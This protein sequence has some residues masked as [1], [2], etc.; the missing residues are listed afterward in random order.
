MVM[1]MISFT[2]MM[3]RQHCVTNGMLVLPLLTLSFT[4]CVLAG[5]MTCFRRLDRIQ[6]A[7]FK[8][9]THG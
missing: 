5:V 6:T 4:C 1:V 7:Y 8:I 2:V 3:I 9:H